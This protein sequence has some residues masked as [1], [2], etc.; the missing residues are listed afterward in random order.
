M[1][2]TRSSA[3][4]LPFIE[5]RAVDFSRRFI[6]SALRSRW[7]CRSPA[8][9]ISRLF[10][11]FV[12][13]KNN[14]PD[15]AH[16]THEMTR[17]QAKSDLTGGGVDGLTAFCP[18]RRCSSVERFRAEVGLKISRLSCVSWA[19]KYPRAAARAE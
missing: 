10:V 14:N 4:V 17:S 7:N 3:R 12:G 8:L 2:A 19:A 11:C 1:K 13:N 18:S 9:R 15:F 16:G 6:M 5:I